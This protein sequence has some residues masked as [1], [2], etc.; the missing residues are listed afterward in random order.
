MN[1]TVNDFQHSIST[2]SA[3]D[4]SLDHHIERPIKILI[5]ETLYQL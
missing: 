4:L 2:R 3:L 1:T 5:G